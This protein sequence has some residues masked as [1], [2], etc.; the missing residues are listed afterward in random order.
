MLS[1][2][3][4]SFSLCPVLRILRGVSTFFAMPERAY[5]PSLAQGSNNPA[6][7]IAPIAVPDE[8][9]IKFAC[10]VAGKFWVKVYAFGAFEL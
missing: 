7:F 4:K 10:R 8:A 2:S 9:L 3:F 5:M 6:I 1:S